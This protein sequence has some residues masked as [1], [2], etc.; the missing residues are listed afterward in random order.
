M[1]DTF[2]YFTNIVDVF[3]SK[4]I[5]YNTLMY[6]TKKIHFLYKTCT[7]T[8]IAR[9]I[10]NKYKCRECAERI[11]EFSS[12]QDANGESI[13]SPEY[14][15]NRL[16][17]SDHAENEEERCFYSKLQEMMR[18]SPIKKINSI[19]IV[20]GDA[21]LDLQKEKGGFDHFYKNIPQIY[22]SD[23]ISK[24]DHIKI[25][26]VIN[27]YL[28]SPTKSHM[29]TMVEKICTPTVKD[30]LNS[31][32]LMKKCLEESAYGN[33]LSNATEWLY[34]LIEK[35][36]QCEK[37][38]VYVKDTDKWNICVEF[39]LKLPISKDYTGYVIETYQTASNNVID[40]MGVASNMECMKKMIEIRM[41]PLNYQ[42]R[43]PTKELSTTQV[44]NAIKVLG[45]FK[46]TIMTVD[47]LSM[48]EPNTIL[49]NDVK[50]DV[51][52]T[53]SVG[54]T[55]NAFEKMGNIISGKN[56][57][58]LHSGGFSLRCGTT[59]TTQIP[60]NIKTISDVLEFCKKN[61]N[62]N[63]EIDTYDM[64]KTYV[65]KTNLDI[66]KLCVPYLWAFSTSKHLI[67]PRFSKVV[68]IVPTY[69]NE[70]IKRYKSVH[71]I[72]KGERP[73]ASRNCC[74]PEF[75]SSEYTRV[76]GPAFEKLN[77]S[78]EIEVP[79]GEVSLACGVGT[80]AINSG[81]MLQKKITLKINDVPFE[82]Y[83]LC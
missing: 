18:R 39:L 69:L 72:I 50:Q 22:R 31:L 68:A 80:S 54:S 25:N 33:I 12:L 4:K 49:L 44:M 71:F 70:K 66:D 38:W 16:S 34:N 32:I 19:Y 52:S 15:Y 58:V 78:V 82:I 63:V 56:R 20:T 53:T 3:N 36:N 9:E 61:E 5:D 2:K 57:G 48:Y 1:S 10:K 47:E 77:T 28:F 81:N 43:E 35:I 83:L 79:I 24:E 67:S 65:A 7:N 42:R 41:S 13:F 51:G 37:E 8:S 14:I 59:S 27:R 73:F 26:F 62:V 45:D 30:G 75:L 46:N 11:A 55:L 17:I 76:C 23:D 21:L 60:T 64:N 40:L 74:F 6:N 29:F